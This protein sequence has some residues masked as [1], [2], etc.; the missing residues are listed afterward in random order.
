MEI[1]RVHRGSTR[2]RYCPTYQKSQ[3]TV[4]WLIGEELALPLP[5][6]RAP[7]Q[8]NGLSLSGA[9][10]VYFKIKFVTR[11]CFYID[12]RDNDTSPTRSWSRKG[13]TFKPL[14]NEFPSAI[15]FWSGSLLKSKTIVSIL[16]EPPRAAIVP[17]PLVRPRETSQTIERFI[18]ASQAR[19]WNK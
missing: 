15:I 5:S 3:P 6:L 18:E 12:P 2:D 17:R 10:G 8:V 16:S 4:E 13:I 9:V 19:N 14:Q 11:I 7:W 1:N